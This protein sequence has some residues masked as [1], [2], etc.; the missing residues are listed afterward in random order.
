MKVSF[1][2]PEFIIELATGFEGIGDD[3]AL[4]IG[5]SRVAYVAHDDSAYAFLPAAEW[6]DA[7]YT[8]GASIQS[9]WPRWK[10]DAEFLRKMLNIAGADLKLIKKALYLYLIVREFGG[11]LW[12][13]KEE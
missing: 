12:E 13:G 3:D 4:E 9:E 10:V 11:K 5:H 1:N 2:V 7:A 6:H 8:K